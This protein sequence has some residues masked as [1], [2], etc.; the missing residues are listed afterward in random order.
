MYKLSVPIMIN[1]LTDETMP[2]YV[3]Q[4]KKAKVERVFL[5]PSGY[6]YDKDNNMLDNEPER[7][8][9]A[10][11]YFRDN[12]FEVGIWISALGHGDCDM[13]YSE[14]EIIYTPIMGING[15]TMKNA[16]CPL[17]ENFQNVFKDA[18]KKL[19]KMNP[20]LIMLDDDFRINGRSYYM[21]CFCE[22]HLEEY[23]KRIGEVIPRE[24]I[25]SRILSGGKNKYRTEYMGLLRDTLIDFAKMLRSAVNEVNE[26]VRLGYAVCFDNLDLLGID[27][28]EIAKAFAGETKPFMRT[29]GAPYWTNDIIDVIEDTRMELD[30]WKDNGVELFIEGDTYPRP[31]YRVPAKLLELFELALIAD[32][33]SDGILKYMFNYTNLPDYETG[34]IE[35]HILNSENREK[36]REIFKDKKSS[37]VWV[38]NEQHKIENW[39][40]KEKIPG[41]ALNRLI[42]TYRSVSRN[43][44]SKNSIPT[45]MEKNGSPVFLVGENARYIDKEDLKNGAILDIKAA[46]ILKERG[47]DTGLISGEK[48][49]FS[50]EHYIS[51]ND[52]ILNP[53]TDET[54]KI[55]ISDRAEVLSVFTPDNTPACYLYENEDG[56]KFMC[57]AYDVYMSPD[58]SVWD[59]HHFFHHEQRYLNYAR[60]YYRAEQIAD[61]L[62][63][64]GKELPVTITKNPNL[65][66]MASES[67]DKM[68][69]LLINVSLDDVISPCITLSKSFSKIECINCTGKIEGNKVYLDDISSYGFSAFEVIK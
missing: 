20:D 46:E 66:V 65:Y 62:K 32:G 25:E 45:S 59:E 17:D 39:D 53:E 4:A 11:K 5:C 1:T 10:I 18:I 60:N 38:Y 35:R 3:E 43:I 48:C 14:K 40:I 23:Y 33:K 64:L 31:R 7:I 61:A 51:K 58:N 67:E 68:A 47:I 49:A 54:Y 6:V 69:V 36:I 9:N 2:I 37:G 24:E 42:A 57:L 30:W 16:N 8:E 41:K 56:L 15:E 21:G 50:G 12:G 44:L 55:K 13:G 19:S 22:K 34:Y 29:I 63:W 26:K 27:A 28:T 52:T